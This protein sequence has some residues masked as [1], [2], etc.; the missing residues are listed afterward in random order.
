W[1]V[2]RGVPGERFFDDAV[3]GFRGKPRPPNAAEH[4]VQGRCPVKAKILPL[5]QLGPRKRLHG[6]EEIEEVFGGC[7][8]PLLL[9][10]TRTRQRNCHD[11][12]SFAQPSTERRA[13]R[14]PS[15]SR[16]VL[17]SLN[18]RKRLLSIAN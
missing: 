18:A 14:D 7:H 1:C 11:G 4:R 10:E 9:S 15:N 12:H 16:V 5:D 17:R 13:Y 6:A 8:A 2:S 3:R